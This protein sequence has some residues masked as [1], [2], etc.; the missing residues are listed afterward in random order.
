[1]PGADAPCYLFYPLPRPAV[2]TAPATDVAVPP[3]LASN[4][5]ETDA[6]LEKL[7]DIDF[8]EMADNMAAW[9]DRWRRE[10]AG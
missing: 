4:I 10:I 3:E 7:F 6:V 8:M 5:V 1:M 2:H 9:S